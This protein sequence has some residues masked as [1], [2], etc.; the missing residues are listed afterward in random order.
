[1]V[2]HGLFILADALSQVLDQVPRMR[3]WDDH[4]DRM[5]ESFMHTHIWMHVSSPRVGTIGTTLTMKRLLN[6]MNTGHLEIYF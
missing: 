5:L 2:D 3:T 1:M 6:T 4:G